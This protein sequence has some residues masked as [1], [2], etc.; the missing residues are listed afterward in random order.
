MGDSRGYVPCVITL[1]ILSTLLLFH[2]CSSGSAIR[3]V[4]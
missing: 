1:E 3:N 2:E 4:I